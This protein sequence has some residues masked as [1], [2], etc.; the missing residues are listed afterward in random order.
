M[1]RK[2]LESKHGG[3]VLI[4]KAADLKSAGPKGPWGFESLALRHFLG[5]L[6]SG[7]DLGSALDDADCARDCARTRFCAR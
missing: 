2:Q 6:Q 7:L 4:G 5:E 1:V 3:L